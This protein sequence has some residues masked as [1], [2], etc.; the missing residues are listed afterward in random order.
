MKHAACLLLVAVLALCAGAASAWAEQAA[1]QVSERAEPSFTVALPV[2]VDGRRTGA[3]EVET[4]VRALVAVPP[5]NLADRLTGVLSDTAQAALTGLGAAPVPVE[6]IRAL[7]LDIVLDPAALTV[8]VSV[9]PALRAPFQASLAADW[10]AP[11]ED[12]IRAEGGAIG[13][14]GA[15]SLF[16]TLDDGRDPAAELDLDG[17]ANIGGYAGISVDFGGRYLVRPDGGS[18]FERRPVY[19]FKDDPARARRWSAGELTVDLGAQT[20]A[21][22]VLGAAFEIDRQGLQPSRNIRP[23]GARSLV[24]ERRSTVEVFVNGVLVD[25]FV[26][27]AGPVEL[28]DI[29]MANLSNDVSIVVEDGFGRREM[30]RFS[31]SADVSLLQPGLTEAALTAGFAR[32]ER[33]GGTSYDLDRPV[34]GLRYARGLTPSLTVGGALGASE[35]VTSAGLVAARAALGGVVQAG[36]TTSRSQAA[37]D[38]AAARLEFRGGPYLDER[39]AFVALRVET[40]SEDFASFDD[41][42]SF[43]DLA[44]TAGGDVR[45]DL[46]DTISG[47]VA[48]FAEGRHGAD[49]GAASLAVS[50]DRRFGAVAVS[51]SLRHTR[52]DGRDPET[53]VFITLSRSLGER[54]AAAASYD[55]FTDTSRV[56]VRRSGRAGP[57]W[58]AARAAAVRRGEETDLSVSV[59]GETERAALRLDADHRPASAGAAER[60]AYSVRAQSGLAFSGGRL[61]VGVDPGDGF[62]MVERHAS[63]KDAEIL[64]RRGSAERAAGR[65][66]RLGPAVLSLAA[67]YRVQRLQVDARNLP[68]GYDLGPGAY[69][70]EPGALTGVRVK[71]GREAFRTAVATLRHEGEP[72]ALRLGELTA[73]DTGETRSFFTNRAGRAAFNGLAPGRYEAR[74]D[75]RAG[76]GFTFE[77]SEESEAYVRLGD[78][79]LAR[80][81]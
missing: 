27:E 73:L 25:R 49:R 59:S 42:E 81:P 29:P 32:R 33:D 34:A 11:G 43:S 6:S 58:G 76:L 70:V 1:G 2:I 52:F 39:N 45:F 44:W 7:G 71:V 30:D 26:A 61:G 24:L 10:A 18:R 65:A 15:L 35:A 79:E 9:P 12:A 41:P 64:V 13:V 60:T 56:E 47:G 28:S 77:I 78:I 54:G 69:D 51:A 4:T 8:V 68:A 16:D 14:T 21:A 50:L 31:L 38:G 72:V 22:S 74:L 17:F 67:P 63:L 66:D 55:S 5:A 40:L 48:A 80:R 62:A 53:G 37:G 36:V 20:G 57:G 75:G 3:L 19:A 46:T 23:T